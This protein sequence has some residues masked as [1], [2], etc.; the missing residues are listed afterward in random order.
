[1]LRILIWPTSITL[2]QSILVLLR[3]ILGWS[4][5]A[6]SLAVPVLTSLGIPTHKLQGLLVCRDLTG[7][8]L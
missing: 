5:T 3:G 2:S 7:L 6:A 8:N 4:H 1:M